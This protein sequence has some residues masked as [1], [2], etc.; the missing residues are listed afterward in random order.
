MG[1]LLS[2]VRRDSVSQVTLD[3]GK[4]SRDSG[5]RESVVGR[6]DECLSFV[7][8]LCNMGDSLT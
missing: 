2:V 3:L 6:G 5:L 4:G 1:R 7:S 8:T